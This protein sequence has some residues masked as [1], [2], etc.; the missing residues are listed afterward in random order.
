MKEHSWT[1]GKMCLKKKCDEL[2]YVP[3]SH[4][5]LS[6]VSNYVTLT[7]LANEIFWLLCGIRFTVYEYALV[8]S[9]H[10][11][12]FLLKKLKCSYAW[13]FLE[14]KLTRSRTNRTNCKKN[15]EKNCNNWIEWILWK[16][17]DLTSFFLCCTTMAMPEL[18]YMV[19]VSL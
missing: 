2:R 11:R 13:Q 3:T 8:S 4:T 5:Y 7:V 6:L 12:N 1:G 16:I 9:V 14:L 10:K 15:V 19:R 18:R 17:E